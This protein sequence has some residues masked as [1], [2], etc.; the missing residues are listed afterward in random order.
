MDEN[1]AELMERVRH[2]VSRVLDASKRAVSSG[3]LSLVRQR[4]LDAL[5]TDPRAPAPLG[6]HLSVEVRMRGDVADIFLNP[7]TQEG[8]RFVRRLEADKAKGRSPEPS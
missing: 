8:G 5:A 3:M 7:R 6:D 2:S 1:A 4:L